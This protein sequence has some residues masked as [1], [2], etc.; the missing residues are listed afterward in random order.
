MRAKEIVS[1]NG[2][3]RDLLDLR[4]FLRLP[5]GRELP[6]SGK[7]IDMRI[8]CWGNIWGSSLSNTFA[9]HFDMCPEF[10]QTYEGNNERDVYMT[11]ML[12]LVWR[13]GKL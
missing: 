9:R 10:P 6:L 1:Y 2:E 4:R 5:N 12:W 7:H 3:V 11:Y 8:V 13:E